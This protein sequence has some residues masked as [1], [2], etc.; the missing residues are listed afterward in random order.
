MPYLD[1]GEAGTPFPLNSFHRNGI[2]EVRKEE[3]G[4][5]AWR[6]WQ[7]D[8]KHDENEDVAVALNKRG[9]G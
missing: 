2:T 6:S 1:R 9:K 4:G 7:L 8:V 5:G 3:R